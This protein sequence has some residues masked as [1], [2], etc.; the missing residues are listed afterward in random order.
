M[1]SWLDRARRAETAGQWRLAAAAYGRAARIQPF[2]YR[3]ATNHG[4]AHW[5]AEEPLKALPTLQR[6]RDL[7]PEDPLPLRGLGNV[8]RDLNQHTAAAAA[9]RSAYSLDPDPHTAWNLS[10]VLI[11]LEAYSEA[12]ALAEQRFAIPSFVFHRPGPCWQGWP[13]CPEITIWSEQGLGDTLQFLRWLL[14]LSHRGYRLHLEVEDCLVSL[15]QEGLQWLPAPVK[16]SAKANP[17][18][19]A[20]CHG[21]LMSLP[22]LLGGAP[23]D[24]RAYGHVAYLRSHRWQRRRG[25]RAQPQVGLIWASGRKLEQPFI[26]REYRRRSLPPTALQA[27]LAGLADRGATL[28]NLQFGHDRDR[29]GPW[30]ERFS[31]TLPASADFATTAAFMAQ[32]DLVISVDT[33]AAHL[34]GATGLPAW[35]LLPWSADPRFNTEGERCPWYPDLTLL[36]QPRPG[37]WGGLVHHVLERFSRW[38]SQP[39]GG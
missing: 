13:D 15:L 33:A 14:P 6:A 10:Q 28:V 19:S 39:A 2:N 9:Y 37:D 22:H 21:S 27:L 29:A 17:G 12:F 16:V 3:L 35:I 25:R 31:E 32:L 5:L 24:P 38:C 36:R 8:F 34:L 26:A 30:L 4:N 11:G 7:A 18:P 20:S 23:L 1:D